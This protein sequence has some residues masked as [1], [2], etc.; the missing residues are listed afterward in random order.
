ML[1]R[2][3]DQACQCPFLDRGDTRCN[4]YFSLDD[5]RHAFD[6]CLNEYEAC[7]LYLRMVA[8]WRRGVDHAILL[9]EDEPDDANIAPAIPITQGALPRRI[10]KPLAG[11]A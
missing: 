11:A 8:E 6:H 9:L 2:M 4:C 7:P 1:G 5:L 10:E 3:K